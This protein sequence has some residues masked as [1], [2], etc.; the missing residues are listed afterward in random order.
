M[1]VARF[2]S[3]RSLVTPCLAVYTVA[4]LRSWARNLDRERYPAAGLF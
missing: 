3:V 4:G 2:L 1:L